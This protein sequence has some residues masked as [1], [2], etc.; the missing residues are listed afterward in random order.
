MI[1]WLVAGDIG[2]SVIG[3]LVVGRLTPFVSLIMS[4][5]LSWPTVGVTG[6]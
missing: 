3:Y 5:L 4:G 1:S 6:T 2:L